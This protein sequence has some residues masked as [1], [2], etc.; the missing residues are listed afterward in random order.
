MKKTAYLL[1]LF[2]ITI[3]F[4]SCNNGKSLQEYLVEAQDKSGFIK[5]DVPTSFLQPNEEFVSKEVKET[6]NSIRKINILM[7]QAKED[8]LARYEAEKAELKTIFKNEDYKSLMSMKSNG[9][10]I[11]LYYTGKTDEIDEVIAFGYGEKV[12]VGVA[13]LLGDNMNPGAIVNMLDKIK[14][15]PSNLNLNQFSGIFSEK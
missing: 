3:F 9:M 7:L 14:M 8:N 4:S 6:L 12:G 13:R 15:D 1:T 11:K 2:A 5:F 10:N